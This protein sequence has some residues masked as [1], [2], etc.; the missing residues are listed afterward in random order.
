M[1]W[2]RWPGV[3]LSRTAATLGDLVWDRGVTGRCCYMSLC[4]ATLMPGNGVRI[5]R[6]NYASLVGDCLASICPE[7]GGSP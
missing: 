3:A 4:M 6:K 5:D 2:L 1:L 7:R